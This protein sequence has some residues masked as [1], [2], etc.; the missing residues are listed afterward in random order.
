V[1]AKSRPALAPVLFYATSPTGEDPSIGFEL[2]ESPESMSVLASPVPELSLDAV[3]TRLRWPRTNGVLVR[4]QDGDE[5][6]IAHGLAFGGL[7]STVREATLFS[8]PLMRISYSPK[9]VNDLSVRRDRVC[10]SR[11]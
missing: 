3:A 7:F 6:G 5:R 9:R 8:G 10:L 4:Q 1:P 2:S 11:A